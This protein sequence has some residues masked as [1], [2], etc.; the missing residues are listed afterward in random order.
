MKN[1]ALITGASSGIGLELAKIHA[2]KGGDLVLIARNE[3]KLTELKNEFESKYKI[4]VYVLSKDLSLKDSPKEIYSEL[5]KAGIQIE[6]LINNAGFGGVG[7]FH[8]RNIEEDLSMIDLNV[9]SLTHLTH[10][11]LNE[12][13]ANNSGRI[14]NVSSTASL[15]PGPL[16]AVY[17][18]SKAFV[19][20]F[21]NALYQELKHTGISVTNLMP[22][23]TETDFGKVS[24]MDKTKLFDKTASARSVALAGYNGMMKGKMDVKAGLSFGQ[25]MMLAFIPFTPK[26]MI[27]KQ[28]E[29]MQQQK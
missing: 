22:G 2:E 11:F 18:A 21:S 24:G 25:K 10:L 15:M 17:F 12:M 1:T 5:Q 27:L 6:L 3:S 16:Q 8:D 13:L 28:V 4:E 29:S 23:A 26:K 20:S 7:K 19:A 9:K 14:L